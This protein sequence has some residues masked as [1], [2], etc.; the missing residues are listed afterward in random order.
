MSKYLSKANENK[1]NENIEIKTEGN[2]VNNEKYVIYLLFEVRPS[3]SISTF[4]EFLISL[5]M[6]KNNKKSKK[7]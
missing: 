7:F 1:N 5:N 4:I 2:N 6:N 3:L